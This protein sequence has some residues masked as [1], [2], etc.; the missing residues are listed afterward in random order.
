M[1]NEIEMIQTLFE[2]QSFDLLPF[3]CS[4]FSTNIHNSV[5]GRL[6][7]H[8]ALQGI[9]MS[10]EEIYK[11]FGEKKLDNCG[12]ILGEKGNLSVLEF[13]ND[14]TIQKFYELIN[15]LE[16]SISNLI[17]KNFVENLYGSTTTI[18]TPEKKIQFWFR[19]SKN[20]PTSRYI[21]GVSSYS[22]GYI[23]APPS[24]IRNENL[25][26]QFELVIGKKPIVFPEQ[27]DYFVKN[28]PK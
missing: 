8:K 9:Q 14:T 19:Y 3:P 1:E 28:L 27:I 17:L 25:V 6:L 11:W 13:N 2:Y 15:K 21:E 7:Y 24:F 18:L 10:E 20:L 23:V 22:K 5:E 26:D 12:L 16:D 4:P